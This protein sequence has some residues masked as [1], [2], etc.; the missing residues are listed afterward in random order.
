MGRICTICTHPERAAIEAAIVSGVANRPIASQFGVGYK[1]VERHAAE[2]IAQAI[3]QS[4]AAREEAQ[5]LNVVQQLR[6]INEVALAIMRES[7]TSK[8]NGMALFAIDRVQ[9]Q[10]ELQ[11]KL[12]GDIDTSQVNIYLSP[13]WQTIRTALVQALLPFPDAGIAVA[14]VLA[15]LDGQYAGLN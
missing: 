12:L 15:G 10:L 13:E 9:K 14:S 7:R 3:K 2:H 11:A 5:A 8:K 1:S 4:Q 6:T